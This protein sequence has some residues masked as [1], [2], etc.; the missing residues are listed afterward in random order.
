MYHPFVTAI[1]C[2]NGKPSDI[3]KYLEKF[4]E[5][6]NHLQEHGILVNSRLFRIHI[7]A[8]ICDRPARSFLKFIINHGGFYSCERCEVPGYRKYNRTL[9]SVTA[10]KP[11]TDSSFRI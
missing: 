6:I 2:G 1:Y 4:V 10:G 3:N 11:R 7:K 5:E 9:Y 8:F